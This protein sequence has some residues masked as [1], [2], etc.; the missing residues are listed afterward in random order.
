MNDQ[1]NALALYSF[2][3]LSWCSIIELRVLVVQDL[4]PEH[5]VPSCR[6]TLCLENSLYVPLVLHQPVCT[7]RVALVLFVRSYVVNR[8]L[9]IYVRAGRAQAIL[10]T[11]TSLTMT[12]STSVFERRTLPTLK[13]GKT[14]LITSGCNTYYILDIIIDS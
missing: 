3:W 11:R 8:R 9:D 14:P 13:R 1:F 4:A 2:I 5:S 7:L 10:R 12:S 6:L